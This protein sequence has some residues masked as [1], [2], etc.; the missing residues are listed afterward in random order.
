MNFNFVGQKIP[1]KDAPFKVTGQAIY[2]DDVELPGMLHGKI[3]YSKYP[4][5][6]ILNIDTSKA[7]RLPG[8][9]AVI[10]AKDFPPG[11]RIGFMRDNP[12]LKG[13]KVLSTRDEIAA[14]CATDPDVAEEALS[15]IDVEYEVL[16]PVFDPFYAIREDAPILH[17]EFGSNV[18]NLPWKLVCG[19]V[20]RA[21]MESAYVV[22]D[23]FTTQWVTHCCLAT[24]GCVAYFD[25][26]NN[27][28]MYSNTQI[29]SLAQNQFLEA[30]LAFGLKNKRVRIIQVTIGGG[31]GSKLDTYPYEYIAILLALKT[32]KPVKIVFSRDE[33]FF[34]TSPRQ[35]T[36]TRISQGC[37]KEGRLTFR[38][39]EMILDNGAYTSWGATTPSVMMMPISS[40]YKVPNV[41]YTAKCVYTNNT[42]CQAMRGYGNPQAT[43]AIE[44]SLDHL[45]EVANIDPLDIRR[46]NAN[47]PGE[48][49]PQGF[50]VTT[51][52]LREC[53]EEVAKRLNWHERRKKGKNRRGV[54]MA[55]LIHVGGGARV[56]KSDGCGTI[57][58]MDD[59]GKVDVFTGASDIG[60]GADTVI[61]QIVAEE[62]GVSVEDVNVI[63]NDTD[64]CPWD[65][66]VHAS[67]TTFVAGNSALYAARKIKLK[68]VEI[69]SNL[70]E[71]PPEDVEI[72]NGVGFSKTDPKKSIPLAKA[73]RRA[74]FTTGGSILMAEHFYDPENENYDKEFRGNLSSAYSYGTHGVEVEVDTET[75]KVKILKYVA[76]H[77]VGRAINPLLLE[78][79]IY[80]AVLQ[81]I[82]FALSER[83]IYENGYLMN[84]NFLDYKILTARDVVPIETVIVETDEKKGPFGAK[85]I[86]EPGLVP[87]APAIANAIYDAIGVRIR[88][89]PITPEKI[90]KALKE[91]EDR[92][93]R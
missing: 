77:D 26:N 69:I 8:V 9:K 78:G 86:G 56:Y 81:G 82:G 91:K 11:F 30:L 73:L 13:N 10:T 43:F 57:I 19:D 76:A 5:A 89:L 3:L 25:V 22:E 34:A 20:E 75:G 17:E 90:L 62:L 66:G 12:P 46:I 41:K 50:K 39:V 7:E 54:G 72:K 29:P 42:Y 1:K 79:Q 21:K 45:A 38:E 52:G 85:G 59:F 44:S 2:I 47:E 14:V 74:H 67:R 37:T 58:K 15:L 4:H 24:S 18:L 88:D 63:H 33:E 64:V 16:N 84:G 6:R 60:Q 31:F 68:L 71:I 27:L 70:L 48:I 28:T 40:L 93:E 83:L 87:T 36:V 61:A 80:G 53:I 49:T 35:C 55:S 32:R 92:G 65:V 23:T 51:C